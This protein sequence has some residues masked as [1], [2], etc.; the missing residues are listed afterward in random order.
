MST[1]LPIK[2]VPSGNEAFA[3][4]HLQSAARS[5][6][7][8]SKSFALAGK[9]LPSAVR[10]PAFVFYSYCRR[11]DD[12]IDHASEP[13]AACEELN[14]E[15]ERIFSGR[16]R[17]TP[18]EQA[19]SALVHAYNLPRAPFDALLE[20][21]AWDAQGRTYDTIEDTIEYGIR[22]A[23]TV[24][25]V[26]AALMGRRERF[27]L[28][29]ACDLGVAMQLTNICRDVGEDAKMG[30]V[31]LPAQWLAQAGLSPNDLIASQAQRE[32][33]APVVERMLGLA[34]ELYR[35]AE[36]GIET[37]PMRCRPAIRAAS[38]IY[39]EIGEEIVAH[40]YDV[41]DRRAVVSKPRKIAL[42]LSAMWET[43]LWPHKSTACDPSCLEGARTLI[44]ETVNQ[45]P[46][47][48]EGVAQPGMQ[49]EE[50]LA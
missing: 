40:G 35:R 29:R 34:R 42:V 4:E 33:L 21:F 8:G 39:A 27:A 46:S 41:Q 10:A 32:K 38:R 6:A 5:I 37:L 15:L 25:I 11:A 45:G 43:W 16:A 23:G 2:G 49:I 19:L 17:H 22:V 36:P 12:A 20:G 3:L 14:D 44:E 31:Y 28:A 47:R 7:A 9:I 13:Q 1:P 48:V 50:Y 24:G 18:Q 26:M 30:R